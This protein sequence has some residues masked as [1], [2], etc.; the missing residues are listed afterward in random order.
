MADPKDGES[1]FR[2]VVRFVANPATDWSDV[3][4]RNDDE[5]DLER[6][7]LK[8]MV[9]RKRRNDFVR[10]REF[11]TLRR[12]R[13]DGLT[14]EQL[15]AL[16]GSSKADDS[17]VRLA[18][19][20]V[21]ARADSGVKAKIDEI[22]LQMVGD[23]TKQARDPAARRPASAAAR[24]MPPVAQRPT[25]FYMA[26]TEPVSFDP[27]QA[28]RAPMPADSG[29]RAPPRD[30]LP[31]LA[32]PAAPVTPAA[33]ALAWA[34]GPGSLAAGDGPPLR[35]PSHGHDGRNSGSGSINNNDN[36]NNNSGS[37]SGSNNGSGSDAARPAVRSAPGQAAAAANDPAQ[38]HRPGAGLPQADTSFSASSRFAVEVSE[39][40]H[41]A[42][43]DEA[44]IAFANADFIQCEQA[45]NALCKVGAPRH[46]H[47]DT[48]HVLLDLYRAT[49]Q[50][51]KFEALSLDYAHQFGRSSPQWYSLPKRLA[52]ATADARP[53]TRGVKGD[54]G[55]ISPELLDV[56]AV[57]KLRSVT[58][59]LPLPW[60]LDWSALQRV[61]VEAASQLQALFRQ[62]APQVI[63]MRW[64]GADCLLAALQDAAPTGVRDADPA[65]WMARLEALRLANRPDQFD[66]TAIDYCVT[67]EVSPPSW[68]KARCQVRISGGGHN[69]SVPPLSIVGEVAS[70]SFESGIM[71]DGQAGS[72]VSTVD[73][74]GQLAGDISATLQEID[75][76]LG[77]A[78]LV[79]V[80]CARLIRVDF[81]AAGDLL[82][83][84]L[85]K[86]TEQRL[87]TFIEA[88]RQV[89]LF[90][91]A[92]GIN[93]QAKVL[94]PRD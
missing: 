28:N 6:S 46:R 20:S 89:A 21:S 80:S 49:G 25:D 41:D 77:P 85:A 79:Q 14:P 72:Q 8:A 15:A 7:E 67:Y 36:N 56:D 51:A 33:S 63:D 26:P 83:W 27:G 18:D 2:K 11:D 75:H 71:D 52:D 50:Q 93:Q 48:W 13:R 55:W 10:K 86:R 65:F 45:L 19:S 31:P 9:E 24:P 23:P 61:D 57:T 76:K 43:L 42:E 47:A 54:V 35:L 68:E 64:L 62:W 40:V 16:G 53:N 1:F 78:K 4:A 92:M 29:L 58:L 3:T 38:E 94:V 37:G 74:S 91:G 73:L 34:Q 44:V 17:E 84:V 12:L 87:V 30:A 32:A 82:N 81:I 70:G 5:Q 22:E 60:V 59:Q 66:E 88:H 69:T 90:F 39:V